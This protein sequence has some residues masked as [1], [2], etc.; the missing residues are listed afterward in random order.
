MR[1]QKITMIVC[2]AV[3]A[4]LVCAYFFVIKPYITKN[5]PV[6]E[7][8]TPELEQGESLGALNRIFMFDAIAADKISKITVEN[9]EGGF[10]FVKNSDG[11]LVIEG[12]EEIPVDAEAVALLKNVTGNTLTTKRVW[13]NCTDE[14]LSEYGLLEP[15]AKWTVESTD[16]KKFTA[17]V[18][19]A[20]LTG[21]GYYVMPEGRR[22]VYTMSNDI[23]ETVLAPVEGFVN[24]VVC[25]GIQQDD[26]YTVDKFTM[27]KNGE[28]MFRIR[29]VDKDKQLNPDALAEN[30]LDYPTSY[31]PNSSLYY[32][33]VYQYMGYVAESCYDIDATDE[34]RAEIGMDDPAHVITFE[35][36]D[37]DYELYFSEKNEDGT[38][39]SES[40]LFPGVIGVCNEKDLKYLEYDLIEWIDPYVF[41]Q[42]ITNISYISVQGSGVSAEF[43]LSHS[44]DEKGQNT[45]LS[46]E[47][48]GAKFSTEDVENFRQYYKGLLA[49]S[50]VDYYADDEY[51]TKTEEEMQALMS[52]E[53]NAMM[54]VHYKTLDGQETTLRFYQYSTRHCVVTVD[55]VG[56]FYLSCDL[57]N[58]VLSDT[59]KVIAGEQVTANAKY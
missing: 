47:Y 12:Y 58:K 1:R 42:Y 11:D 53:K 54:T 52:D 30:I 35:Y 17:Y 13:S 20:L 24:P 40:S 15:Q 31:Y 37:T 2:A 4:L 49:L 59:S 43:E 34:E 33:V 25:A 27:Y 21:G 45:V 32:E 9:D 57:V 3:L 14:K 46:V 8:T 38:Y 29:L 18:G 50:V 28:K 6:E 16:G 10:V 19:D 23:K 39:Y 41:Q 26:F 36:G 56:E 48:G 55:G 22:T 5:A 44:L 51:C 7:D